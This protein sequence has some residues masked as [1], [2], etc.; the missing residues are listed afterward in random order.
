MVATL[1][2]RCAGLHCCRIRY[3]VL[4]LCRHNNVDT[5]KVVQHAVYMPLQIAAA[6]KPPDLPCLC[7]CIAADITGALKSALPQGSISTGCPITAYKQLE[8]GTIQLLGPAAS[9][10]GSSSDAEVIA[11]CKI[12]I[13]RH[14]QT[15]W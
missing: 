8:D 12:V 9:S 2:Q 11:T 7:V 6:H 10:S 13:G 15:S 5:C 3:A 1:Q 14:H 4:V